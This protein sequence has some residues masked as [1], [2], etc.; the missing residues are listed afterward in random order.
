MKKLVILMVLMLSVMMFG[1]GKQETEAST[2]ETAK[3]ESAGSVIIETGNKVTSYLT[4]KQVDESIG[5]FR[6]ISVMF[7]NVEAGCPQTGISRA[8]V[9]YE[10]PLA[11]NTTRLIGIIE[12]WHDLEKIGSIR[13]TRDYY[14]SFALE[15]DAI[16]VHF[17]QATAYVGDMLNSDLVDN[18]SGRV[19]GIDRPA[20]N[21]FYRTDDRKAPHNLYASA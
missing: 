10:A 18:I 14:V 6:P 17:G 2:D 8:D 20:D 11:S 16:H 15:F 13:S 19:A 9:V 1:C 5:R 12:D 21:A 4:G 7:N 3:G